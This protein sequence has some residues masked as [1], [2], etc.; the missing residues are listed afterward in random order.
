MKTIQTN[1]QITGIRSKVDRSLG[2]SI[3]TP[4]YTPEESAE[5]LR[6]QGMNVTITITPLDEKSTEILKIDRESGAKSPSERM[7]GVIFRIWEGKKDTWP[8]Y[9]AYYRH[10]MEKLLDQLKEKI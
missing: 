4:E 10:I 6:L 8:D 2:I 3:S 9:E 1:A 7:R 5:M